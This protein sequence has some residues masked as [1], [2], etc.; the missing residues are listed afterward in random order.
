[1]PAKGGVLV[2]LALALMITACGNTPLP[3]PPTGPTPTPGLMQ[4]PTVSPTPN[5]Q[6]SPTD[7]ATPTP[8]PAP[9]GLH[10][11]GLANVTVDRL[12]QMADPNNPNDHA[13]E[14]PGQVLERTLVPI[15]RDQ[16][17]LLVDGPSR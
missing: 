4:T 2:P 9:T 13:F 6:S 3:I 14:G 11:N 12:R 5:V 8:T 15:R 1:M 7:N 17:V 16:E 10:A